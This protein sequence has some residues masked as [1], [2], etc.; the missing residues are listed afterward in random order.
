MIDAYILIMTE[1]G[2]QGQVAQELANAPGV[3][4]ADV[5]AG[6]YDVVARVA[7]VDLDSLGKLTVTNI[8]AVNG[9]ARTLTC[10]IVD[11]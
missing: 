5:V 11:L 10:P 4:R 8:Q 1:V 3:M 2:K 9:V 7:A 6:P